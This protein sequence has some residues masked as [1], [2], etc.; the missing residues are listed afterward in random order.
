MSWYHTFGTVYFGGG[1]GD[2]PPTP[3]P[4]NYVAMLDGTQAW[5]LSEQM[6]DVDNLD[7]LLIQGYWEAG[8]GIMI[9]QGN[10]NGADFRVYEDSGKITAQIGG[11]YTVEFA[12]SVTG[13]VEILF[14]G[15][16]ISYSVDGVEFHNGPYNIGELRRNDVTVLGGRIN[17]DGSVGFSKQGF[18]KD[19]TISK[20]GTVTFDS[21]LTDKDAGATQVS[22]AG[23]VT[24]TMVNYDPSVWV[25]YRD[26][27]WFAYLDGTSQAWSFGEKLIDVDN[28]DGTT[29]EVEFNTDTDGTMIGQCVGSSAQR[30][31]QY[32]KFGDDVYI[33]VGGVD[34]LIGYVGTIGIHKLVFDN[35]NLTI[36]INDIEVYSGVYPTGASREPTAVTTIS[37]RGG[38]NYKEGGALNFKITKNGVVT[39]ENSLHSREERGLQQPTV[40]TA[41]G[42]LENFNPSV[43][44][45]YYVSDMDIP[46]SQMIVFAGASIMERSFDQTARTEAAYSAKGLEIT[47]FC[48]ALGGDTTL[49]GRIKAVSAV[50]EFSRVTKEK[51]LF[52]H[53][54]GNDATLYGPYPGGATE[55]GENLSALVETYKQAGFKMIMT[56]ISYRIPPASNPTQPYNL[57][58]V[59]GLV[60]GL[61]DHSVDMYTFTLTS[62]DAYFGTGGGDGVHPSNPDGEILTVNY[63]VDNTYQYIQGLQ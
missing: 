51:I 27:D 38:G 47:S 5:E 57:N 6:I 45:D 19:I 33:R 29:I 22:T 46:T 26:P 16:N 3:E 41:I 25:E 18:M 59:D 61:A 39:Y 2:A 34:Q 55:L 9:G 40:G 49:D 14:S 36:T 28:L 48:R 62:G 12:D 13:Y 4:L 44:R 31:F 20:N 10:S 32:F 37:R 8:Q 54:G 17:G 21:T 24:A 35:G 60:S 7:G 42:T 50:R 56:P 15:G 23:S 63:V 43:W 58:I 11:D 30:E 53:A 1:G 52:V